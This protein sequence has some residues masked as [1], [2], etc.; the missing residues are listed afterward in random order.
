MVRIGIIGYGYWGP[1]LVRNFYETPGLTVAAVADLDSKKLDAVRQR[2][3]ATRTTGDFRD[4]LADPSIDAIAVATPVDTH[5]RLGMAALGAGK[6][7][8]MEKPMAESSEQARR[9]LDEARKRD[10]VLMVDHTFVY[11]DAVR[12]IEELVRGGDLGRIYYYDSIRV[13]LGLFQRDVSVIADLAVHDFSILD[14]LLDER[15]AAVTASGMNHFPGTPENLAYVTLFYDSGT[16][17]HVNVSWLAPVKV[18][19]IL[20]GGSR[21]MIRYDDLEPSE[22]IKVYDKGV[23]FTD[24]PE[25]ILQMRVGYRTGD[26]WAPR[27][28]VTEALRVEA[29]HFVDCI[30]NGTRPRTGGEMGLNVVELIEAASTSMRRRGETVQIKRQENEW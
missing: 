4:L 27:L 24:D 23:D 7:L 3:P 30:E 1:N 13:N 29:E 5:Y 8:W 15:P 22:K 28:A 11:T 17:A 21:K 25:Q 9:L 18:R 2:Y 10:R 16:I 14:C 20:L 6:H 12:K 26:M 19:Q